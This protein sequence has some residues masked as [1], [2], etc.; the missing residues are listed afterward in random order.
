MKKHSLSTK[1]LLFG[2]AFLLSFLGLTV[3]L[4]TYQRDEKRFVNLTAKLFSQEMA[5]N[6]LNLHY[7]LANPADF[8]IQEYEAVLSLYDSEDALRGQAGMENTL[9]ALHA[10]RRDKLSDSDAYLWR[11]LTRSLENSLALGNF[12]YYREPL[13]PASGAQTQLPILLAE[14]TFRSRRDVEDYLALLDQ[15][16]EYFASLLTYEQKK[17]AAGFPM[18]AAFLQSVREQCDTIV[19]KEALAEGTH[20]LQTTFQERLEELSRKNLITAKEA[21]HYLAQNERLLGTVLLPAY[22]E[23]GDG[24]LVLEDNDVL[25]QGLAALPEGKAYYEQLLI[26][27]TGSYRS[28]EEIQQLLTQQFSKEY[29]AVRKLVQQH[30]ELAGEYG[31]N[32]AAAFPYTDASQMLLDLK[33]RMAADFPSIPAGAVDVHV[34]AVDQSLAAYCAP[35]FYLT[36][37]LDDT[38]SN[39]IYINREKTPDGLDLYTTLAHEGYPG[40]L[41]QTVYHNRSSLAAG[42][43][44]ARELLWYGGYQEGWALYVEFLS[45]GYAAD[46]LREHGQGSAALTAAL[47]AHNRSL[48]LCLYSMIDILIHYEGTSYS[49]IAKILEGFGITDSASAKKIYNYIVQQPCNYL[50]YYLGYLEILSLQEEARHLWGHEYTDLRFHSFYLDCGPSDFLSLRERLQEEAPNPGAPL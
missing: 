50:K 36:A 11:L 30:P 39:T 23:L 34:K 37:P 12:P 10:L 14:Y 22:A 16:D 13:S 48:Q 31:Q 5:A 38:D 15:T 35:A 28:V 8:G 27:Q 44:P 9:A 21:D 45:F 41:Y 47:E 17:T 2:L 24:L 46:L 49:Q 4:F 3:F 32:T 26:S 20:F 43:R 19:T 18:P 7:T 33:Q 1:Q 42:E 40:H 6:T 29:E 25:P